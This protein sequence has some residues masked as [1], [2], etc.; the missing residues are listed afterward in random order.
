MSIGGTYVLYA[1]SCVLGASIRGNVGLWGQAGFK[2]K[3][4]LLGK[5]KPSDPLISLQ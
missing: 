5:G 3:P 1:P 2:G 4:E